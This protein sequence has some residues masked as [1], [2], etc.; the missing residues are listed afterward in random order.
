VIPKVEYQPL[1]DDLKSEIRD[2]LLDQ[3]VRT[4]LDEKMLAVMKDLKT[5]QASE[6]VFVVRLSAENRDISDEDLYEKMRD[7]AKVMN[8]E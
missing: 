3:K 1:D 7:H 6:P 4:S 2:Q 8:E 5:L